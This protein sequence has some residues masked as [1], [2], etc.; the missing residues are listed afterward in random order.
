MLVS[1]L[2]KLACVL[3]LTKIH[4]V[5]YKECVISHIWETNGKLSHVPN[6]LQPE[7]LSPLATSPP[8]VPV[9]GGVARS[10]MYS[11]CGRV[12]VFCINIQY[13]SENQSNSLFKFPQYRRRMRE[14]ERVRVR[15]PKHPASIG[16][17]LA[18]TFSSTFPST[19]SI[20]EFHARNS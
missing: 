16:S 6:T 12:R 2:T 20:E 4:L 3:K 5:L 17:A 9:G 8:C 19:P 18:P 14:R 7:R 15:D 10:L 1:N 11:D 13:M